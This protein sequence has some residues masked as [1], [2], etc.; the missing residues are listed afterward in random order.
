MYPFTGAVVGGSAG[1]L[2]GP[3]TAGLGAGSGY[4][5]GVLMKSERDGS[6]TEE[7]LEEI[8]ETVDALTRGDVNALV[9]QQLDSKMEEERGFLEKTLENLYALLEIA[10]WVVGLIV[11]VPLLYAWW[12]KHKATPY[13]KAQEAL[14]DEVKD[15][16]DRVL[17]NP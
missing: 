4:A 16:K 8:Q 2:G 3:V 6:E 13:Y 10:A 17:G 12:R 15:L 1:S 5:L 9:Q 7:A 14:M 11:L